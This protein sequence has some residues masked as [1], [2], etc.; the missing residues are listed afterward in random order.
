ME[1]GA[2]AQFLEARAYCILLST[3]WEL[4]PPFYYLQTLSRIFYL[5]SVGREGQ[6]FGQQCVLGSTGRSTEVTWHR[7][8]VL[9][10]RYRDSC[11]RN[12]ANVNDESKNLS[13]QVMLS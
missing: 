7:S 4:N 13:T 1:V 9:D 2:G 10:Q 5:A 11:T 3:G 12:R 8:W 6:D